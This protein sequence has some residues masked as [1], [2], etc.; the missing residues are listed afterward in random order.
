MTTPFPPNIFLD[1][2]F[3]PMSMECDAPDLVV[4]G[5]LP[6]DLQ[7]VYYRN[8]PDPLHPPKEGEEYH[9]FHGDGMIQRFEFMDGKV[10]WRNRWVH[11]RKYE[12]E[13]AAGKSLFG[14]MGNPFTND[15]SV[16]AEPYN[17]GNTSVVYHGDKLLALM[18]GTNAVELDAGSLET[19]G[20]FNY[21]GAIE[22]PITA[23]PKIDPQSGEMVFFGSQAGG[24]G[25]PDIGHYVA[26]A[27]GALTH[28][29]VIE[30]PFPSMIH[31]FCVTPNYSI[32]PV[33]P[34]VF[35]IERAMQGEIPMVWDPDKGTH[36]G[37]VP[38]H[39]SAADVRW[40]NMDARFMFHMM[41]AYED[42][43]KLVMDVTAS[44]ATLFGPKPD[45]SM[46][47]ASDGLNPNLRRWEIDLTAT[48]AG[49]KETVI[50][51]YT[52]E[53]PRTDDR[54]STLSYRH[55]FTGGN[56]HNEAL[57]FSELVH[58]DM[59]TGARAVYD[60]GGNYLFGEPVFAPRQGSTAEADGYVLVLAY[61]QE[62]RL[63]EFMVFAALD[64][65]KGP[66]AKVMMPV[67]IPAGFHGWWVGADAF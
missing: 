40:F 37:V 35:S 29:S 18:E 51:D 38:R 46:A 59:E 63:T 31:D 12:L 17:T 10:S 21:H 65:E 24:P 3:A 5:E 28:Q 16:A 54:V 53:F 42:G 39:G 15:P 30:G 49:V 7:G 60:G 22:G 52:V 58:Y 11:T 62:T 41:N 9:W 4:Q 43:D 64:I 45:G 55:G 8:G 13:R 36:F 34:I 27:S 6:T 47:D 44:N 1:G 67:R 56:G 23:H 61:N 33:F 19:I 32:F 48:T 66:V 26:D 20:D 50:D 2:Y 57:T 25:S 14:V